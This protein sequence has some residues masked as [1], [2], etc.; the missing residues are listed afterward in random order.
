MELGQ[1][2][3]SIGGWAW[4]GSAWQGGTCSGSWEGGG[5]GGVRSKE[6]KQTRLV[7]GRTRNPFV[8]V[9]AELGEEAGQTSYFNRKKNEETIAR[10]PGQKNFFQFTAFIVKGGDLQWGSKANVCGGKKRRKRS[11]ME[12]GARENSKK[13]VYPSLVVKETFRG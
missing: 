5:V 2:G 11:S 12:F 9:H 1:K 10:H 8:V 3:P 7:R 4:L 6:I 13:P